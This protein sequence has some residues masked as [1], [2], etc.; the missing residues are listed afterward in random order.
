M[1]FDLTPL[2]PRFGVRIE[3]ID[4][5]AM[6][7]AIFAR[8]RAAF[9]EHSLLLFPG[10]T[11]DD[12]AHLRLARLFGPIEDRNAAERAPGE[13]YKVPEVSNLRPDGTTVPA[14]DLHMLNLKANMLWH[15]DSTFMPA[16]ALANI[17]IARTVT[18]NGGQTEFACSRAAF[19]DLP[20]ARKEQ[21]RRRAFR[22][23]YA[24]SRAQISEEL[25]A[26][27]MFHKWEDQIWRAIW[28][29]P[30]NG[31]EAIYI[32]SHVCAVEGMDPESGAALIGELLKYV[33]RDEY[34][35]SHTWNVGDVIVWDQRAVL[36]RARPWNEEEPRRLTSL[37]VSATS[38][39]G[40]EEMKVTDQIR[41][42]P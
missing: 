26:M 40:L 17:L 8:L 42:L 18:R 41:G 28:P 13:A 2:H 19:A 12:A 34:V 16:P 32:A 5:A 36:H 4:L 11:L 9:E 1:T 22:H 30:V 14:D 10:Q 35:F 23:R 39:D 7:P 29:N 3:G 25:A 31:R 37:C 24:H 38:A 27:P 6:T 21:L 15:S 20:E 33:A